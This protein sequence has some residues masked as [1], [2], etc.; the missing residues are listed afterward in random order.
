MDFKEI[1]KHIKNKKYL[2]SIHAEE[3]MVKDGLT[4]KDAE[5]AIL[6]GEVI[7]ERLND[8]RGESRLVAGENNIGK[9]IHVVIGLRI[10]VP[11][12]VTTYLPNEKEW[13]YGKIRKRRKL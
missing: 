11:V 8:P 3:E 12:I 4:T 13:E 1:K 7:E 9:R 6:S 2:I 10:G 5:E